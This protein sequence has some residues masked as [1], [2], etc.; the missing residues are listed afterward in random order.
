[1]EAHE[2]AINV[3]ETSQHAATSCS[4]DEMVLLETDRSN[5]SRALSEQEFV[6]TVQE[7]VDEDVEDHVEEELLLE[8]APATR[9]SRVVDGED[10]T[11]AAVDGDEVESAP[12][13][14]TRVVELAEV[15]QELEVLELD[16]GITATLDPDL[17][18]CNEESL[19]LSV[20]TGLEQAGELP[21]FC[22][23]LHVDVVNDS[24]ATAPVE[25][26]LEGMAQQVA[27]GNAPTPTLDEQ[28]S[29]EDSAS[30]EPRVL[31][32]VRL[33][34]PAKSAAPME[35]MTDATSST[36]TIISED[37][38]PE[39]SAVVPVVVGAG[40]VVEPAELERKKDQEDNKIAPLMV[41]PKITVQLCGDEEPFA[42]NLVP[43]L[44][45]R[46][47]ASEAE[48]KREQEINVAQRKQKT[49]RTS[50]HAHR[51]RRPA[52]HATCSSS[53]TTILTLVTSPSVAPVKNGEAGKNKTDTAG[54]SATQDFES[55]VVPAG[56]VI[57]EQDCISMCDS[58][59]LGSLQTL[60]AGAS[61]T[62]VEDPCMLTPSRSSPLPA[63]AFGTDVYLGVF[64]FYA[65]D[66]LCM[67][68]HATERT[69]GK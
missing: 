35:Q 17:L 15:T 63:F 6:L 32:I 12:V 65:Y 39:A 52:G 14:T 11:L 45:K 42:P 34:T 20:D 25:D 27:V 67:A 69:Q 9:R 59:F 36:S 23:A 57:P 51:H 33:P 16:D 44:T 21:A 66:F 37:D 40:Q 49:A 43:L 24:R 38:V 61:T 50:S 46:L 31:D 13:E 53:D 41:P 1:M 68:D 58:S 3:D 18:V 30:P 56:V 8:G 2:G 7:V 19:P 28:A 48:A 55:V 4:A 22:A 10:T 62:S 47:E 64:P 54:D 60:N 29:C 26:S 5:T